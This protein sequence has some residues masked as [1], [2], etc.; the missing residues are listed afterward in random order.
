ELP[1]LPG[2]RPGDQVLHSVRHGGPGRRPRAGEWREPDGRPFGRFPTGSG[3]RACQPAH[4]TRLRPAHWVNGRWGELQPGLLPVS[5]PVCRRLAGEVR[6][7]RRLT[8]SR[9]PSLFLPARAWNLRRVRMLC[10]AST[11]PILLP[12]HAP[13]RRHAKSVPDALKNRLT[14]ASFAKRSVCKASIIQPGPRR[15]SPELS[16][17]IPPVSPADPA[18]VASRVRSLRAH[19]ARG[20]LTI[21]GMKER[22]ATWAFHGT[23]EKGRIIIY[24]R[25]SILSFSSPCH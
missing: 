21:A 2:L 20:R 18:P 25:I 10:S 16:L 12:L 4:S 24:R 14:A 22:T 13:R 11:R 1:R 19:C 15:E 9:V 5:G 23:I 3:F 7:Q 17:V 6:V 8:L